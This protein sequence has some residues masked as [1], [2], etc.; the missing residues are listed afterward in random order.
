MT[1]LSDLI[2]RVEIATGQERGLD[3]LLA[4]MAGWEWHGDGPIDE[5]PG[6]AGH[7]VPP[8]HP[9]NGTFGKRG[10][11][12]CDCDTADGGEPPHYTASIDAVFDL[13][14]AILPGAQIEVTNIGYATVRPAS[15]PKFGQSF[16]A[17]NKT[18]TRPTVPLAALSA[19]LRA[20]AES[21]SAT[22]RDES[23]S[24]Q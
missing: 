4:V 10:R 15:G 24:A 3:A 11:G 6:W 20:Y 13:V 17:S 7:W 2:A 22:A 21:G 16:A 8:G 14:D 5:F 18:E 9:M 1:H 23:G 19:L 12:L